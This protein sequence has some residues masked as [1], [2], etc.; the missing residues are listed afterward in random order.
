MSQRTHIFLAT[1]PASRGEITLALRIAKE[2]TDQGDR[3]IFLASRAELEVFR[4]RP[5]EFLPVDEMRNNFESNMNHLVSSY[6]ADSIVLVDILTNSVTM[7]YYKMPRI[8]FEKTNLPIIAL[9]VYRLTGDRQKGDLFF[10]YEA[11]FR[12]LNSFPTL[13]LFP[14]PFQPPLKSPGYYG[15]LPSFVRSEEAE[16]QQLREELGFSNKHKIVLMVGTAW[17]V[18]SFW[19]D[20]NCRRISL[21]SPVLLS[22]YL[23]K[24]HED[25]RVIHIGPEPYR[26]TERLRNK[27]FWMPPVDAKR[28]QT[29][30]STT[31]LFLTLN[32]V[33]TTLSTAIAAK[34]PMVVVSNSH[35]I[36]SMDEAL[37]KIPPN[38]SQGLMNWLHAAL[39]IYPFLAWPIGYQRLVSPL[40]ENNPFC[41]TYRSVEMFEEDDFM[42][43][44]S[45]LLFD[46]TKREAMKKAQQ[47]YEE[48][49]RTLP[50]GA[51]LINEHL[52]QRN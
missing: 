4:G 52:N 6:H 1:F 7:D 17:Q 50:R 33:G 28:F 40:L 35:R 45:E 13:R 20:V 49:V 2:L 24:L 32:L 25:V 43:A 9:D 29:I 11:D 34:L 30:V 15:A 38:P 51:D 5:V 3:I 42:R 36:V 27:Y 18:P 47:D 21:L 44:C 31:D 46:Q 14:V 12:Y 8:F 22:D 48:L 16:C 39:P 41:N 10:D 19:E 26:I 37:A 23:S